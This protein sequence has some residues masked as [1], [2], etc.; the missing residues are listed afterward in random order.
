M[1]VMPRGETPDNAQQRALDEV[2]ALL[3]AVAK[4]TGATLI[5]LKDKLRDGPGGTISKEMM[6]DFLH[7]A[8]KGYAIWADALRPHLP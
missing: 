8:E 7:P 1:A 6:P 4:L 2:N 3:P 5:D